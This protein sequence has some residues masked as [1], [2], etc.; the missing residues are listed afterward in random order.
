MATTETYSPP[1]SIGGLQRLGMGVGLFGFVLTIVGFVLSGQE[2]FFQAYLVAYTFWFGII[3]GSMALLMV[4][5]L[6]GGAWGIVIRR[7]LEAVVRTMPIMAVLFIPIVLGIHDLYHWSHA[8]VAANDPIIAQKAAYLN[9][10]FFIARQVIYFVIWIAMSTLLTRYSAEQDRTGDPGLVRKLSILSGAG[11]VIYSL[12]VTFAMVDWTMSINPHWYSTMWGPLYMAGQGLSAMA[13]AIVIVIMLSQTAPLNHVITHHHL[14]DLGK[15]LF[16]FLMLWAYLSFSQF[17]IIWS[18]NVV[19]EIPHYLIRWED[20]YQ[21]LSGFIIIGHFIVPYV[22]LLSRDVKR[23]WKR[24]RVIALWI[25]FARIVDYYWHV[26]PEFHKEGLSIGL[27]DLATP[28]AIGGIFLALFAANLKG[29]SL[30]PVNDPG[31]PKALAH[32]VH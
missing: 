17:L 15:F 22:L 6:S 19:E 23:D 26:A 31:L 8:D 20:G 30:L 32:H 4:Q 3:L 29:R 11:L 24:L 1:E 28:L 16:A 13:F 10:P 25:L 2:K 14:H 27:L 18:A 12:T 7:P 9:T 5:H 21:W